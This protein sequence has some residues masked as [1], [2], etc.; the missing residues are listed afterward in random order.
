V[1]ALIKS[2]DGCL[3]ITQE[4]NNKGKNLSNQDRELRWTHINEAYI[5]LPVTIIVNPKNWLGSP[6]CS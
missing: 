5:S 4:T 6:F 2:I 3:K 1:Q